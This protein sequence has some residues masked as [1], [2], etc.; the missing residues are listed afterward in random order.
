MAPA[1]AAP[2]A[3]PPAATAPA[4]PAAKAQLQVD[5]LAAYDRQDWPTCAALLA[6][7]E[8]WYDAACCSARAGDLATAFA[9]LDR[10]FTAGFRDVAH[11]QDDP[12]LASL[13]ADPRW[14]TAVATAPGTALIDDDG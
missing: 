6:A 2:A 12:D 10:A 3:P 11:L 8:D 5:G 9:S 13:H 4:P 14:G 7:A 1:I